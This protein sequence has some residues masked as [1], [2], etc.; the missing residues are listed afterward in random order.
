MEALL[1]LIA[2]AAVFGAV[3]YPALRRRR[4]RKEGA[5][6]LA[7][8]VD[9]TA[10]YGFVPPDELDVRL[11]GPD[12]ELVEALEET[13]R[14]QDWQPVARL[15]AFTGDEYELRWQRV[16][17]LAGAAAMELARARKDGHQ[18]PSEA[19]D[20]VSF[21]KEPR[22]AD[23]RWLREWR[24]RQPRDHGGAQVYAQFLVFQALADTS[25][26]RRIFLEEARNVARDAAS[27]A[28]EDPTPYLTELVVARHLRYSE[29]EFDA[30]WSTVRRLAPHHM[31]AHLAAL[32]YWTALDSGAKERTDAFAQA[33]AAQAPEG[34]LLPALPLFA[35]YDH[36]P[37][38]NVVRGLYQSETVRNAIE[39]AEYAVDQV[40]DDHPVRPH[41]LHLLVWFLVRA[42]RYE[43]AMEALAAVDGHVGAVPWV[44][45]G[46]PAAAYTAYRALAVAGWEA[47]S[48]P[49][50]RRT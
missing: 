10:G 34:T 30:V 46:D 31:G 38:V 4:L 17:S 40:E 8:A 9:P 18:E 41:V 14:T 13:Q 1:L 45:E 49:H 39:A 16:Q 23:A 22:P 29:A 47:A 28:S 48:G 6:G 19:V 7:Q 32:A 11:P 42:E 33:A 12:R 2:L 43:E 36:L 27:L 15:L 5:Q 20:T 50:A 3:G 25:E 37:E 44:D 21:S 24:A 35:V 26:D